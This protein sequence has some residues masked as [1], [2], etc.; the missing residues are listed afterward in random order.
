MN[1]NFLQYVGHRG[2]SNPR[3][4]ITTDQAHNICILLSTTK[5]SYERIARRT[6]SSRYIVRQIQRRR[7]WVH[8]SHYYPLRDNKNST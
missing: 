2:D 3:A 1:L 7:T 8:I 6:K 5:W 4:K